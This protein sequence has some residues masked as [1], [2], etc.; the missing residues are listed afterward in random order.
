MMNRIDRVLLELRQDSIAEGVRAKLEGSQTP[1][2]DI[3]KSKLRFQYM[4]ANLHKYDYTIIPDANHVL[5]KFGRGGS[6]VFD[7]GGNVIQNDSAVENEI[8][9]AKKVILEAFSGSVGVAPQYYKPGSKEKNPDRIAWS[10]WV[11][12]LNK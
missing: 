12:S 8:K 6:A 2:F 4:R 7:F 11:D 1:K 10:A 3:S 5:V 9:E